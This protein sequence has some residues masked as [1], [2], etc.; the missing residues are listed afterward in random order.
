MGTLALRFQFI[1][2]TVLCCILTRVFPARFCTAILGA[3]AVLVMAE[4]SA[5]SVRL[6]GRTDT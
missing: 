3:I 6:S 2:K 4:A 5:L 1:C